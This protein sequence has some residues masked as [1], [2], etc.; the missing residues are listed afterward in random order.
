MAVTKSMRFQIFRRDGHVCQYCG[1]TPPD[2][3][4]VVDHV[5]PAALGGPDTP[6]NLVTSCRECNSGKS[7]T[8]PD[9]PV[10]EAV[11]E[12]QRAYLAQMERLAQEAQDHRES[13]DLDWFTQSWEKCLWGSGWNRDAGPAELPDNWAASVRTWLSRGLTPHDIE[14]AMRKAQDKDRMRS[15]DV[16]RYMAGVCWRML[17]Q[18]EEAAAE[19]LNGA[20]E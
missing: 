3:A 7:A 2:V 6:D 17:T 11:S 19:A 10:V 5:V 9:A 16:F 14:F 13:R 20:P 1:G 15:D 12:R 4:L 8:P 18:R